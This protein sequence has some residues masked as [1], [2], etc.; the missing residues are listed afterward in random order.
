MPSQGVKKT[1]MK[2]VRVV[3]PDKVKNATPEVKFIAENV[4]TQLNA[5]FTLFRKSEM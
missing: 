1:Y 2:A 4:L 3:H 5:Q